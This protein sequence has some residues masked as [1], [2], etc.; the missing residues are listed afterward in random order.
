MRFIDGSDAQNKQIVSNLMELV[1][2]E[3]SRA[4]DDY[5]SLNPTVSEP[6]Q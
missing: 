4:R 3:R 2:N 6:G 1:N 5:L